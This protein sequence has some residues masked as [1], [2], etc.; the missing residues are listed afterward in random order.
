MQQP[1]H[2]KGTKGVFRQ[3][4]RGLSRRHRHL[5]INRLEEHVRHLRQVFTALW[6]NKLYVRNEKCKF[7]LRQISFLG[8]I[9]RHGRIRM[10]SQKIKAIVD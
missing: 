6:V 9:V 8:H 1:Y 7:G 2:A 3:V 5:Y 4:R 10:D